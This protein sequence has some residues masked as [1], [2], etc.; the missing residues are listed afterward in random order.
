[1]PLLSKKAASVLDRS[2]PTISKEL[3]TLGYDLVSGGTDTH[4]VLIDLTKNNV[5][6]KIVEQTLEKAGITTNKN[7]VPFDK[8]SPMI[9]SGLR[10]GTPAM[11]TRGIGIDEMKTIAQLMDKIIQNIDNETAINSVK[12]NVD[13]LCRLFPLYNN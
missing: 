3:L 8:R 9:T 4:V 10:I 7:M 12:S 6:G 1:M 5:T 13:E 11:T 2:N